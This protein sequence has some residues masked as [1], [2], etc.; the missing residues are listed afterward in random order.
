[1]ATWV[2]KA[3]PAVSLGLGANNHDIQEES[4]VK[5]ELSGKVGSTPPASIAH[6]RPA[7]FM[8][9]TQ[10]PIFVQRRQRCI[11]GLDS[12]ICIE[13]GFRNALNCP[14]RLW[15]TVLEA[16]SCMSAV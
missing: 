6:R 5:K 13:I 8:R 4:K 7:C 1:M 12:R 16:S 9:Q 14:P 11:T 3:W 15:S 10:P 2:R